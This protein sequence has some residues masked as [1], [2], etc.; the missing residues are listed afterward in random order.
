MKKNI[1]IVL[2]ILAAV[3]I[4]FR[5]ENKNYYDM[6]NA[7]SG[8]TP[9]AIA[10]DVPKGVSLVIDGLVKQEYRFSASA[11]NGFAS[12]RIRTREFTPDGK[13]LGAYA[14]TGIPVFNILEGIAPQKDKDALFNQPL[15]ILVRFISSSGKSV[16]FT[17]TE[18][19]MADD[20]LPVTLAFYREE[21]K[22]TADSVKDTYDKNIFNGLLAGLRLIAPSEPDVSRYLDDVVKITYTT[23]PAPDN[24]LPIRKKAKCVSTAITCIDGGNRY[25]AAFENIPRIEKKEWVLIG[26]GH[27]YEDKVDSEGFELRAF[28][29]ANFKEITPDDYFLFVACDGY[30]CLFSWHEIFAVEKGKEIMIADSVNGKLPETGYRLA[31][32]ADFFNDRSMWGVAYVVKINGKLN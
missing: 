9:L 26:H 2:L 11:L 30:R 22:P 13:F 21:I 8:A 19:I 15:D 12:T 23:L 20:S 3:F 7:V 29:K 28:L 31:P 10:K 14:Y 25:Q 1:I 32:T 18:L 16:G 17:F 27:G 4:Y 24:L 5:Q 6:V